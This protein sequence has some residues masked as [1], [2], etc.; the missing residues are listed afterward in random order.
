MFLRSMRPCGSMP[1]AGSS[2]RRTWGLGIKVLASI[3]RCRMPRDSSPTMRLAL[4][5]QADHVEVIGHGMA[6]LR[7]V[8]PVAGGEQ[9]E[10]LPDHEVL[11]DGR[12]VGHEADDP[13]DVLGPLADVHA[14]DLDL[15]VGRL[16][17]AEHGAH[18]GRLAG[19]VGADQPA[20]LARPDLEREVA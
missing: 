12:E 11:V 4:L 16:E 17:Q 14:H 1:L 8:Q 2:S 10:E 3:I 7:A 15:A 20:D 18:R 5:G 13:A 6:A 9:V 19:A